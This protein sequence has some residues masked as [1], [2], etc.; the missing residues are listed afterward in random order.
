MNRDCCQAIEELLVDFADGALARD[1]AARVRAHTEHCP[2][3]RE[4]VEA[5][6]QSLRSAG[7]IWQDNLHSTRAVR[8]GRGSVWRYV[9]VA[10]GIVLAAGGLWYGS[11]RHRPAEKAPTLA[12]M[13]H[14]I[15]ASGAAARLLVAAGQ[16]ETQA[17]L[18]DVAEGQYRYILQKYPDTEAAGQARLK[19]ESFR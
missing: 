3:C 19:L 6:G 5:L 13:E 17:S 18:R 8:V 15:V 11:V 7:I 2:R 9:A 14:R 16:L 10:A 1:E 4:M 12:E